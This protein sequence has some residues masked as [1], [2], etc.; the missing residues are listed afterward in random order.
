MKRVLD[1]VV[2]GGAVI[3][4]GLIALNLGL[5]FIG[6]MFFLAS[7]IASVYLLSNSNSPKSLMYTNIFFIVMNIIGIIR[8]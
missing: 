4:S 3:G 6:Y 1:F 8:A 7:S 2:L 5:N